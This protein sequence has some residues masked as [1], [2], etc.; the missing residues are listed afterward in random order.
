MIRYECDRCGCQLKANDSERFIVKM[1]IYGAAG[2]LEF[3]ET[4]LQRDLESEMKSL[5]DQLATADPDQIEDQTYRCLRFDLCSACQRY[6]LKNPLG[7]PP[8]AKPETP[9]EPQA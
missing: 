9:T 6:L 2:P 7:Q 8:N 4:D 5:V 3:T 1:E